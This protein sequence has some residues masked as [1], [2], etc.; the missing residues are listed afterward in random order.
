MDSRATGAQWSGGKAMNRCRRLVGYTL[1]EVALLAGACSP[2][3]DS[4]TTTAAPATTSPATTTTTAAPATTTGAPAPEPEIFVNLVWHQHQPRYPLDEN[5]VVTR[6]WVRVHATKDYYD[7]AALVEEFPDLHVT[8]NLTPPLLLQLEELAGG[9]KDI[10]WTTA[11]V[12]AAE[13]TDEQMKFLMERFFDTNS[14]VI[15]RFPR[16]QELADKRTAAGGFSAP[17][18]TFEEAEYRDLQVLFNLAWTDPSFLASAPLDGL[19]AKGRD[20]AEDDKATVFTEHLRIIKEVIP[21]HARLWESGQIEV[22]TTPLAHPILPL[23]ADTSLATVGDPAAL[24]PDNRF[25]QVMDA[26]EH[27]AAGLDVAERL[28]GTRPTGMWPGEG[29]VAELVMWLFSKNGVEWVATGQEV[30][31]NSIGIGSFTRDSAEVVEQADLLYRPRSADVTNRD[32]VAMYF[33]D[34]RLSDLIGFEYSNRSADEAADDLISRLQAI[35]GR[36]GELDPEP[37]VPYV[38]SIILDGENA[39]ENYPNDGIDFLRALYGRLT[40]TD[41]ITTITPSDYLA[42][43]GEPEV[44]S[45][46]H[47]GAWF[48]PNFATWIG[49]PEEAT[50]WDYLFTVRE[51]LA[52]AERSGQHDETTLQAARRAMLFAEG[53]DWF[54][55]Y[56]D[57]QD[58]GDDGYFD[59]AY[60]DLLRS[61]YAEL[62]QTPPGFLEVP[63]IP[64]LPIIPTRA[65]GELA[66]IIVDGAIE[67]AWADQGAVTAGDIE[68]GW[69]F[70][71]D[72]LYMR[73]SGVDAP[74]SLYLGTPEGKTVATALDGSILGYGATVRVDVAAA[75]TACIGPADIDSCLPELD[76][77]VG[78]AATELAIPLST[79]GALEPGDRLLLKAMT[80]D[81]ELLPA[82]GPIPLQVPD[83]S[84]VDVVLS[85]V[86]PSGDDHGPGT[87]T[88]PTDAVFAAGSYDLTL[89]EVGTEGDDVVFSFEVDARI[90]NPWGSPRGLSVQTFDVYIDTDPG[91]GTGA[92][93]LIAGRNAAL[94]AGNGWEYGITLEG[95]QPA[96]YTADPDGTT[97]E[98]TPS[99]D[100]AVFGDKGKV[101][102]RIDRS[103]FADGD[104]S[105][106]G[107]AVAVMSQEGFPSS[108]VR[109]VRDV[110]AD[111]GQWVLGG[112]PPDANHT[113]IVDVAWAMPGEQETLLS[114]YPAVNDMGGLTADD[115]GVIPLILAE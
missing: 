89:F 22:T 32:P 13:L 25:R 75:G 62:G 48:Q 7:M 60:R 88:Y 57:D 109:R 30:L 4:A 71:T 84:N 72:N 56:G 11:E 74:L 21:L 37:D 50:A 63:I 99:F 51:D 34:G 108:G 18:D 39:W 65:A 12:P 42:R 9:T 101:Q 96:I 85:I 80:A 52:A 112:A 24:L 46:V 5:G 58:S 38:V 104:L 98:T 105:S 16:Y 8:F 6:P 43:F 82:E 106:W 86:D 15:A 54:W 23:I 94:A 93:E 83:I 59:R 61:V 33:R 110:G 47:P 97:I 36:L 20:F 49:E 77:V 67:D 35:R 41:G 81:G 90:Q 100:V 31:A 78:A 17:I 29:S 69:A 28:L 26:D 115:F 73:S 19:V 102:M 95:W 113:R 70:D 103:L 68:F 1:L 76:V 114:S 66:T 53:S 55:W 45:E 2:G 3:G 64:Q 87:Y 111:S 44:V 91:A 107:Y 92:R 27:V 14:Q 40:S 10:Y 79:L